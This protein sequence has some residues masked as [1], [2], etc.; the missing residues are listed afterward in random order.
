MKS[1]GKLAV[2][3]VVLALLSAMPLTAQIMN[4]MSFKTSF[5]FY[6]GNAK[7]PAG[8]YTVTQSDIDTN[9]LLIQSADAKYSAYVDCIPTQSESSHAKTDATFNKYGS[10]DYL[11]RIWIESQQSGLQVVQ[12][13]AEK[14]AAASGAPQQHSVPGTKR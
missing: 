7:L 9:T 2:R 6:A 4:G 14:K 3:T 5:P 12:T 10:T 1:V 13:K 11:A 8:T